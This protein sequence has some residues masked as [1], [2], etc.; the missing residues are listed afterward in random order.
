MLNRSPFMESSLI[1][2][3][4]NNKTMIIPHTICQS[5]EISVIVGLNTVFAKAESRKLG[6]MID[7]KSRE[8]ELICNFK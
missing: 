3:I 1:S 8:E 5:L 6:K 2:Y 7:T 4:G